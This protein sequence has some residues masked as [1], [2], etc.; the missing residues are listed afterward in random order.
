MSEAQ[1]TTWRT[2]LILLALFVVV[3]LAALYGT[4]WSIVSIWLRSDTFAHG[5]LIVPIAGWLVWQKREALA[6]L[7]PSPTL[8]P[9]ILLAG[10][11]AAWLLSRLVDVLVV[12]QF[13][14]VA[15]LLIGIW[16]L[17]GSR[18]AW[19]MAF[20][21]GYLLF[22]VPVGEGL[23]PPMM[24]L[25]ADFTVWAVRATGIPVYREGLFFSLPSGNWSVVEA[26]SGV[27]YLIAS[28]TL[29]CLYA[30]I[31]Y[32]S[33]TKRLVF[34]LFSILVPIA[35]NGLRAYMIVMIG[36]LSGMEYA[37]G[38][39][40][41]VYGWFFFGI[42]MLILFAV[43][44]IWRDEEGGLEALPAADARAGSARSG[45]ST[46]IALLVVS[47]AWPTLAA[48]MLRATPIDEGYSLAITAPEDLTESRLLWDWA[49]R[50]QGADGESTVFY[51]DGNT[52]VSLNLAHYLA[53]RQDHELVNSR[54]LDV[55]PETEAWRVLSRGSLVVE[56]GG[57][58]LRA[59]QLSV[60]ESRARQQHLEV[61]NWYRV[62]QYATA[63]DYVAKLYE[64]LNRLTF[65]RQDAAKISLAQPVAPGETLT[66]A[67][68]QPWLDRLVPS[69]E[70]ALD[71]GSDTAT[72]GRSP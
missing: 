56:I 57:E 41:L 63:N 4:A 58:T 48:V 14:L 34:I 44:A 26:C 70:A 20:P 38:V 68:W 5:F 52:T 3:L 39:D 7:T 66:A 28:L 1:T 45:V 23:V 17:L 36:H 9:L 67:D 46:L 6:T 19:A 10:A 71:Q 27:R 30:Y 32:R 29:G 15:M 61:L 8:L 54:N 12:Q 50:H 65:G 69:I 31:T 13:A 55:D 64:A 42:V 72:E 11:G 43:G 59:R 18:L 40:H 16:V 53:Q 47:L 35:A 2:T 33:L 21:L 49:P 22:A 24:E 25:T 51:S 60:R 37:T 62:G